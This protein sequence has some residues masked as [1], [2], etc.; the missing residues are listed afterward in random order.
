MIL[1]KIAN[2]NNLLSKKI[3]FIL[4]TL[5]VFFSAF[6][7]FQTQ[8]IDYDEA[9]ST[10]FNIF[11]EA[12]QLIFIFTIFFVIFP[13]FYKSKAIF[14]KIPTSLMFLLVFNI[15]L[16]AKM[17]YYEVPDFEKPI[18]GS[19]FLICVSNLATKL[20]IS[21]GKGSLLDALILASIFWF[22]FSIY[23]YLATTQ[24]V[25]HRG[26][27]FFIFANPQFAAISFAAVIPL[28]ISRISSFK[29]VI[30]I[31][32]GCLYL[33]IVLVYIYLTG[34]RIGILLY[35]MALIAFMINKALSNGFYLIIFFM[36]FSV[37]IFIILSGDVMSPDIVYQFNSYLFERGNTRE[38]VFG[39][40]VKEFIGWPIIG[41]PFDLYD[42]VVNE[43]SL[44]STAKNLGLVGLLPLVGLYATSLYK[45]FCFFKSKIEYLYGISITIILLL[46][47]SIV[48]GYLVGYTTP[49]LLIFIACLSVK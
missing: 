11:I 1:Y 30:P 7:H 29:K 25:E 33:F 45:A 10:I 49:H 27:F 34:S 35:A 15:I 32:F 23:E 13:F 24:G 19:I 6:G 48:E 12:K 22:I 40:L 46:I 4:L 16:S 42:Y 37:I 36:I 31:L 14:Y 28:I 43:S 5:V 17:F 2:N 20:V 47:G 38:L 26:R 8:G 9:H 18:L 21:E 41:V 3:V 44:L 39:D